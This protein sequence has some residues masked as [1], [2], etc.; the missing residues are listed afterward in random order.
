MEAK[1]ETRVLGILKERIKNDCEWA[2]RTSVGRTLDTIVHGYRALYVAPLLRSTDELSS[3]G[4]MGLDSICPV[5]GRGRLE[6]KL[7]EVDSVRTGLGC[8]WLTKYGHVSSDMA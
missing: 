5:V 3:A 1:R 7:A 2:L 8:F 6:G 4:S